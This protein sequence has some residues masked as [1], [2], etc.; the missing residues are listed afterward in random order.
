MMCVQVQVSRAHVN[1]NQSHSLSSSSSAS[2]HLLA[3]LCDVTTTSLYNTRMTSCEQL[4]RR[5]PEKTLTIDSD[6]S[7]CHDDMVDDMQLLGVDERT[8]TTMTLPDVV[9]TNDAVQLDAAPVRRRQV[10]SRHKTSSA[11]ASSTTT[12]AV[13]NRLTCTSRTKRRSRVHAVC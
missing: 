1:T 10:R 11:I 2:I 4:Q 8:T 3:S 9:A 6:T 12:V 5:L 13:R 7:D